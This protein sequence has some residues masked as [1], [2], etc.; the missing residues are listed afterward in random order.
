MLSV[1]ISGI[2]FSKPIVDSMVLAPIS[3]TDTSRG[4]VV[5][6]KQPTNGKHRSQ[7][8]SRLRDQSHSVLDSLAPRFTKKQGDMGRFAGTSH[9]EQ[10]LGDYP[11]GDGSRE[12]IFREN[13]RLVIHQ[14][15][16]TTVISTPH[17][18][19]TNARSAP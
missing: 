15:R 5:S 16:S 12:R 1:F 6:N 3:I 2:P 10:E 13:G 18:H 7:G 4:Y 19:Q 14:T 8:A 9:A 17:D 11:G